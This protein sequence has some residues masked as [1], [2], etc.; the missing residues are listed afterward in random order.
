M[1]MAGWKGKAR[2][3]IAS[4]APRTHAILSLLS[5]PICTPPP[6]SF[7]FDGN[8]SQC[9]NV[10]NACERGCVVP[11]SVPPS[12]VPLPPSESS[13]SSRPRCDV[14]TYRERVSVVDT[15]RAY[16]CGPSVEVDRRRSPS[17]RRQT[18]RTCR[19]DVGTYRMRAIVVT[20]SFVI[21]FQE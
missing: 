8:L 18:V 6:P 13:S 12:H 2:S 20:A 4:N 7:L 5:T 15:T 1:E 10:S 21:S 16:V 3:C 17:P 19:H 11:V 14:G 9:R